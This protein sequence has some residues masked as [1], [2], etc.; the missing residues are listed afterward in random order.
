MTE[1]SILQRDYILVEQQRYYH[2]NLIGELIKIRSIEIDNIPQNLEA[3]V[4]LDDSKFM[5]HHAPG[6]QA[7]Q[8]HQL[9]EKS[10][11][12]HK[13]IID[14]V[15]VFL[16]FESKYHN[17]KNVFRI[18]L[19]WIVGGIGT[20]TILR[21]NTDQIKRLDIDGGI[22]T[23]EFWVYYDQCQRAYLSQFR[24]KRD[25]K[26][27]IEEARVG[28]DGTDITNYLLGWKK[29]GDRYLEP[30][31][32]IIITMVNKLV[33][34]YHPTFTKNIEEYL[35]GPLCKIVADYVIH[36]V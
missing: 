24:Y 4:K 36:K 12:E 8:Q 5:T 13:N 3:L 35:F 11:S 28:R 6:C 31:V 10:E 29:S 1:V 30:N 20:L 18:N 27:I 19:A 22:Y 23:T 7:I 17:S 25:N 33:D 26:T 15:C 16:S 2:F 21:R 9:D 14:Q 34:I 32:V